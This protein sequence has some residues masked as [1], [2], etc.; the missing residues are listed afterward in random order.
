MSTAET[1]QSAAAT[2]GATASATDAATDS[3]SAPHRT[4]FVTSYEGALGPMTLA[5]AVGEEL[6]EGGALTGV[7]F[8]GQAHDRAGL[9][10][11]AV[12]VGAGEPE[13]PAVLGRARAWLDVAL[14]G[15]DPG[16]RPALAPSGTGFQ[17]LVWEELRAIPRGWTRTYGQIAKAVTERAGHYVS[18]RAVGGAV[19]RNPLSVVVPCHRVVAADGALTGYAGGADRKTRLLLAEGVD[20]PGPELPQDSL[21][22]L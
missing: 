11:D 8:D 19:G 9:P 12:M 6:P 13:E 21:P 4:V 14:A 17:E 15:G 3:A 20:L 18:P 5:A 1:S 7:W 22:G 16:E 10:D 2:D